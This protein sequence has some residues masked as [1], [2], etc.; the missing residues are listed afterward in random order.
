MLSYRK[1]FKELIQAY[2]ATRIANRKKQKAS[3]ID[4]DNSD[5]NSSDYVKS[6]GEETSLSNS[7][8]DEGGNTYKNWEVNGANDYASREKIQLTVEY[9]EDE[10][11]IT[12]LSDDF[13]GTLFH[14]EMIESLYGNFYYKKFTETSH[15]CYVFSFLYLV[16]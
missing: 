6:A 2:K 13:D 12:P 5:T 10:L 1:D 8:D 16:E 14:F 4:N 7:E 15:A 3:A 11:D 9:L